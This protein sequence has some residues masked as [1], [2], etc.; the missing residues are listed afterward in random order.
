[1]ELEKCVS[2]VR[3][4]CSINWGSSPKVGE[5]LSTTFVSLLMPKQHKADLILASE[6]SLLS[7]SQ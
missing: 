3:G 4:R 5:S 1:M 7:I 2:I 6:T